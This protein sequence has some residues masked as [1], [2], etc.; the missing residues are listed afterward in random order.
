MTLTQPVIYDLATDYA[1]FGLAK[2]QADA[3]L[4]HRF[5]G[6]RSGGIQGR[7]LKLVYHIQD[8][9]TNGSLPYW[10]SVEASSHYMVQRDGSILKVIPEAHGAWTNGDVMGANYA[11]VGDVLNL[12]GNANV[13]CITVESEGHPFDPQTQA[14]LDSLEWLARDVMRRY[15]EIGVEDIEEHASFNSVTRANCAGMYY[16]AI[17]KRLAGGTTKVYADPVLYD[18]LNQDDLRQS[19]DRKMG[20]TTFWSL[21]RDWTVKTKTPRLQTARMTDKIEK[22]V[23]PYLKPKETFIGEG[24]FFT[25]HAG[26]VLT[27]FGTR[28]S[29][30]DLV[31]P[32]FLES[33]LKQLAAA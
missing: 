25:K 14:Q 26:W 33:Y 19:L 22:M 29:M 9:W 11:E 12:G 24:V 13:W 30:A 7:P 20:T 1:R 32:P 10:V 4:T 8:G 17:T 18:W 3:I 15:D 6:R 5:E 31:V 28:V 16:D 27:A 21:R 23:G 2:W